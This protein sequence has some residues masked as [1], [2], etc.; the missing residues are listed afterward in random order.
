MALRNVRIE[1]DDILRKKSRK[2]EKIDDRVL[3]ILDDMLDTMYYSDGVGLAGPQ[4]GILK[5]LVV[6]DVDDGNVYK[7]IN[8]VVT[9]KSGEVIGEEGC[10]SVPNKRGKVKRPTNVTVEYTDENGKKNELK[11]EGLLAI[12]ICH[13][14]DHLEGILFIDKIV[15]E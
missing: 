6:I 11:A 15:G 5:R 2:V 1:G 12:C 4:I 3:T 8:P 10:L 14:L 7:M 13:E 9:Q